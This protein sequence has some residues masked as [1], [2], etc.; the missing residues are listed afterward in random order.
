MK[1]VYQKP[2]MKVY[3]MKHDTVLLVGSGEEKSSPKRHGGEMGYIPGITDDSH[4]A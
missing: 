4:L 2:T 3:E 1:K